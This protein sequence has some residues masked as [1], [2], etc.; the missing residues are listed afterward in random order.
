VLRAV[1]ARTERLRLTAVLALALAAGLVTWLLVGRSTSEEK[2]PSVPGAP[3]SAGMSAAGLTSFA[4]SYGGPVYWTGPRAG[5]VYEVTK[6]AG[7]RVYVRY[8][9]SQAEVG[10]ARPDFLTVGT[11][12]EPGAM[13]Q[14]Q[15]AAKRPGAVT[16]A[17]LGGGLAVYDRG[18]PTSVFL[19]YPGSPV[20]VEV[21][22]PSP[23]EA[24]QLVQSGQ[25]RPID[26]QPETA[27]VASRLVSAA[28]LR[29]FASTRRGA[30]YWAGQRRGAVYELTEAA[31]GRVYV[32]YLRR[33]SEL[34]SRRP[35]FLTVG[36]YPQTDAYAQIQAAAKRRGAVSIQL[37][38][39]GLAVYDRARPTSIYLAYPGGD[40]Q[41]EVY[42]PSAGEARRLV[43]SGTIRLAG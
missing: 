42:D 22:D 34:G 5:A 3:A 11:Y 2:T 28:Q 12:P 17:L 24:R 7:G 41:V 31:Q 20:Q 13:A 29:T 18:K 26:V 32:R 14:I 16:I 1:A 21:Y 35:A 27:T 23:E 38:D 43:R 39:G 10:S 30:V 37:G 40:V 19:A 15:A 25:V 33:R 8:L 6:A 36:T 9:R 4:R